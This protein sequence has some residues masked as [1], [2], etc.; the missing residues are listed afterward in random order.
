MENT[1]E[2]TIPELV[3]DAATIMSSGNP[4]FV[5][6]VLVQLWTKGT[7]EDCEAFLR[8][9]SSGKNVTLPITEKMEAAIDEALNTIASNWKE[10][11][12]K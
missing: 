12:I 10:R 6:H 9:A 5:Q 11:G 8:N 4:E 2:A 1:R 3:A 7:Y